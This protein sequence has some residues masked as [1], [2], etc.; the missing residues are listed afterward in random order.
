MRNAVRKNY[1]RTTL[2]MLGPN[3]LVLLIENS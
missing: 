3:V 1:R 2:T